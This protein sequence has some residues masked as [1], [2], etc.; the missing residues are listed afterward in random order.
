MSGA[1]TSSC[2]SRAMTGG[3]GASAS[4][5]LSIWPRAPVRVEALVEQACTLHRPV[6]QDKRVELVWHAPEGVVLPS[7]RTRVLQVLNNLIHN[8]L[9]FTDAGRIEVS[10]RVD[11]GQ[12]IFEVSDTGCG[13]PPDLHE[14]IFERF[15]QADAFL[16]R[17]QGG[18]GLG[19]A[20]CRELIELMGGR[21]WLESAPGKGSVFRFSLPLEVEGSVQ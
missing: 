13:I 18:T 5:T 1:M 15:R 8:A 2:C 16:T 6:A 11:A 19:L 3:C 7:D 4:C 14:A 10:V 21:I 20:L 12:C 17:S 9:K